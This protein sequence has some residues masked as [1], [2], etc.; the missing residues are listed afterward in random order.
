M[1]I[2]VDRM[3][4]LAGIT[5][6]SSQAGSLNES[7]HY[8]A[9]HSDEKDSVEEMFAS[10][11]MNEMDDDEGLDEVIEIDEVML[12]QEL[13]R[14]K[15][16]MNESRKRKLAESRQE[17]ELKKIIEEEVQNL[18]GDMNLNASWMYGSKKPKR[19]RKG[20]THQGS[21]LKGIGF[22]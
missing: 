16:L 11:E 13:R 6:K 18:F 21:Y 3:A 12:V 1:K 14:A 7:M 19:S 15:K 4:L 20:F 9:S 10:D 8:E 5:P 17:T 2:N 22:E